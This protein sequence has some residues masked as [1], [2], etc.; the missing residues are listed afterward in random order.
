WVSESVRP[1]KI[2]ED[3]GFQSLTKTGRPECYIPSVSTV[4]HN[5]KLVFVQTRKQIA[6]MLQN[7][8]GNLNFAMD[9]WTSLN[10]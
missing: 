10:H 2:V 3:C 7:Y 4:S 9:A 5:I 6:R 1:F 8:E